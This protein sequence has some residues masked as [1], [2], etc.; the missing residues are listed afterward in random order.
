MWRPFLRLRLFALLFETAGPPPLHRLVQSGA[1]LAVWTGL[2]R[3]PGMAETTVFVATVLTALAIGH[4]A[5]AR[6]LPEK[7]GH[8]ATALSLIV[9]FCLIAVIYGII[10][11]SPDPVWVQH[12]FTIV[13]ALFALGCF[14]DIV[15]RTEGFG[16]DW[17]PDDA[18]NK[19]RP[20]LTRAFLL[21]HL[22][23]AVL[24]ATL[25]ASV[26]LDAWVMWFAVLPLVNHY[27]TAG[28]TTTVLLDAGE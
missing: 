10:L 1:A 16:R 26:S 12:L 7:V 25:V 2:S 19:A 6:T 20:M 8:E 11:L 27:L 15:S 9:F 5:N 28:L 21:K 18:M 24:N 3:I 13:P 4:A 22:S 14:L 23:M 17:W